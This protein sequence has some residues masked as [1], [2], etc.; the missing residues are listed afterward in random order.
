MT[1][2][3]TSQHD[4]GTATRIDRDSS[5]TSVKK[6][7]RFCKAQTITNNLEILSL[8]TKTRRLLLIDYIHEQISIHIS[9]NRYLFSIS[10]RNCSLF[11]SISR[12]VR[13]NEH[14][15][16]MRVPEL[17]QQTLDSHTYWQPHTPQIGLQLQK[18]IHT[19]RR[20]FS[21]RKD[22]H[23]IAIYLDNSN[24]WRLTCS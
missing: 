9:M 2:H 18:C 16:I 6:G 13:K 8:E 5:Q 10:A 14:K 20:K 15:N 19:R 21:S 24:L 7:L 17:R 4:T 23:Y 1:E 12:P 11:L 3:R 22:Y